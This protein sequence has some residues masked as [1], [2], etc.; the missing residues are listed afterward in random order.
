MR[1]YA[2]PV[3]HSGGLPSSGAGARLNAVDPVVFDSFVGPE[4]Q[5]HFHRRRQPLKALAEFDLAA[6]FLL[7]RESDLEKSGRRRAA[8]SIDRYDGGPSPLACRRLHSGEVD[9][10]DD[11]GR[12]AARLT[13]GVRHANESQTARQ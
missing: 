8:R 2:V 13:D 7:P 1:W 10:L 4:I 11:Q 9:L 3:G 6:V 5:P 12:L